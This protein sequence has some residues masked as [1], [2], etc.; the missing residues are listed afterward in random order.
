M[1]RSTRTIR[2]AFILVALGPLARAQDTAS[3]LTIDDAVALALKGNRQVQSS[4]LDVDRAREDTAALKTTRLPQFQIYALGG[5]ALRPIR[6]MIP[7]GA[8]GSYAATGPIPAQSSSITTPSQ[9]TAVIL[10]Q[11]TQP[12]SQL[13]KIH[14][15][16]IS[17]QIGEDLSK[18][19]LR[20]QR[21]ETAQ[22]VRDL[23]YQTTQTQTQIESGEAMVKYLV[24]LQGETDRNLAER[25]ALK[26][27]SLA[28][29]ARLSQQRYQL[30]NLR[31]ASKTQKESF[32]RLLGRNLE[33]E[34]SVEVQPLPTAEEIDL[35]AAH[36]LALRQRP[37]IQEARLQTK[38][39]E[40]Q[41]RRERAEYIPDFSAGFTY[42][43]FPNVSF[44]PQNF[45]NVGFVVQWQPFDWGQKR[46][47]TQALRDATKQAT[48]G[49][50]DTEQQTLL[51][52]NTKFRALA[53]ARV[54][55]D[56][57]ALAQE[58]QREKLREMTNQYKEKAVLLS[59]VLQQEGAVV[60]ADSEY[61]SALAAFWKAKAGFDRA[62]GRE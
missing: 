26:G 25:A 28:V 17:S 51:D 43:A 41:V 30:L 31:N 57:S 10:G 33:T 47:K 61:Q 37:E 9:F 7:K 11:A 6:F 40:T 58:T 18:Q 50:R 16:L 32:N 22:S 44:L 13:W 52:V 27:D 59:D 35:G 36:D 20:R 5:E 12:L 19:R 14:L 34:F 39:A 8:L 24:E 23:Y 15:D 4:A 3:V 38:K 2:W 55:L 29:R 21:Q 54:L 42:A 45:M 60:Q 48:L 1:Q 46:H 53:E 56:T 62:T 49:E